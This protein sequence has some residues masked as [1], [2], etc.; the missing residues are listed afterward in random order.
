ME[1]DD[2]DDGTLQ[3]KCECEQKGDELRRKKNLLQN[4]MLLI[5]IKDSIP[6]K[7]DLQQILTIKSTQN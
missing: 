3:I 5:V 7:F 1:T 2:D 4:T 6:I